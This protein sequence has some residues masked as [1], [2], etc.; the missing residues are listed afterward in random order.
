M[1]KQVPGDKRKRSQF[2][3]FQN[4]VNSF[5]SR[6]A[7]PLK[8]THSLRKK[9]DVQFFLNRT[10]SHFSTFQSL[11]NTSYSRPALLLKPTHSL[12]KKNMV[13]KFFALKIF[14]SRALSESF[15]STLPSITCLKYSFPQK[16]Q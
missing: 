9:N 12:F 11:V 3:T 14:F 1:I 5:Y 7:L 13:Q 2:S 15:I 10:Q 4:F 8:L 16:I 6:T